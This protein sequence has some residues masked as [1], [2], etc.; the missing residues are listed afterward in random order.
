MVNYNGGERV[1]EAV[2][3]VLASQMP[4]QLVVAD[5]GSRDASLVGLRGLAAG[6][7]SMELIELRENLGF[8]RACNRAIAATRGDWLLVLNPDCMLEPGTLGEMMAVVRERS[9]VG[10]AGCL[11]VDGDGQEQRGC[12]RSLPR[13]GS[14]LATA[15][16]L[17]RAEGRAGEHRGSI[18]LHLQPLPQQPTPV[19]AISGAFML[20]RRG[21]LTQVGPLDEGYFLHCEDLDWCRRFLDRGWQILFVPSVRVT[22]HQGTCSAATPIRV[23]WHKHRGML[24][25]YRKHL[26]ATQPFGM[27]LLVWGGVWGRFGIVLV[28]LLLG[29]LLGRGG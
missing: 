18:N 21:A 3:R 24:R 16:T 14:G 13:L 6:D 19:E 20:L 25:Y 23:E 29:R 7:S 27:G 26:A 28:R 15:L 2:R 10:M 17:K 9:E 4:I 22:H 8:A 12:R 11:I 5:N 1:L